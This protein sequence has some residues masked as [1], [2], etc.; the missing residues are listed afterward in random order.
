MPHTDLSAP[1]TR[2]DF[3]RL[4][5]QPVETDIKMADGIFAKQ[6]LVKKRGTVLPQHAH[7][8]DHVSFISAGAVTVHVDGELLGTF[9]APAGIVIKA[10][11]KHL[12]VTIADDTVISCIHRID[13]TGEIDVIEEHQIV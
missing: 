4:D 5:E 3:V 9:G 13:R 12:F 1:T 6:I 2:D 8:W 10:G 7:A 11:M